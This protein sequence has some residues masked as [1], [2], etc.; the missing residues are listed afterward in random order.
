M[1][2]LNNILY[3]FLLV[4]FCFGNNA[5]QTGEEEEK[6]KPGQYS[7]WKEH[8]PLKSETNPNYK[9][10]CQAKCGERCGSAHKGV[11]ICGS[12]FE[13]ADDPNDNSTVNSTYLWWFQKVQIFTDHK[14]K[15]YYFL[16]Y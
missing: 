5:I 7:Q 3:L 6:V 12:M 15:N 2:A 16:Q 1:K 11:S 13:Y 14:N 8:L 4:K 9:P 10:N